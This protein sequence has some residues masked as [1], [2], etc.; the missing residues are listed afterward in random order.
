[1]EF[2]FETPTRLTFILPIRIILVANST[3]PIMVLNLNHVKNIL[4]F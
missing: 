4:Y 2:P 1:M 3:L